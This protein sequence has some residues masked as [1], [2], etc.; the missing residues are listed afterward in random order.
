MK[1]LYFPA[2]RRKS[3]LFYLAALDFDPFKLSNSFTKLSSFQLQ[4][5]YSNVVLSI[6][7]AL[8]KK[9]PLKENVI[10][11]KYVTWKRSLY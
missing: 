8:F 4:V 1:D 3:S 7:T 11:T 9:E 10:V 2:K 5:P 6:K